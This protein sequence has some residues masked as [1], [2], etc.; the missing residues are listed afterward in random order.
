MTISAVV[1]DI[2]F[3]GS[4]GAG[5]LGPFSLLKSGTPI[6]FYSNS[7]IYV[8]R[9]DTIDDET[10]TL[11]VEGTDYDLTGGPTAG[12]I[13][14]TSPQTG[15]LTAERL[16]VVRKQ[17]LAQALDLVNGGN[18]SSSN[19]ERRLDV[20]E[21]KLQDHARDIKST[22]RLAMFDTDEIPS[23]APL[24]AALGKIAYVSGTT[25]NPVID[26]VDPAALGDTS[27]LD[28]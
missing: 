12:S 1:P 19:L 13:T 5:T 21:T 11:L 20:I 2:A 10:P 18:F 14:L 22:I 17:V 15:L 9:Y 24:G 27:E 4:G 28:E 25:A 26:F 8:Y 7:D 23:T 16:Y 3:T 6:V